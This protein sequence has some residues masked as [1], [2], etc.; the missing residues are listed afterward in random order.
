MRVSH[1]IWYIYNVDIL[2]QKIIAIFYGGE[3]FTVKE[4]FLIHGIREELN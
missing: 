2:K 1:G 4:T 3:M